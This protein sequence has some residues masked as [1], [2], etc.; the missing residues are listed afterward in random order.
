MIK[1]RKIL[2]KSFLKKIEPRE[3]ARPQARA[4]FWLLIIFIVVIGRVLLLQPSSTGAVIADPYLIMYDPLE[5]EATIIANNGM[6][7]GLEFV[8]GHLGKGAF[9]KY[10]DSLVYDA[11]NGFS[12]DRGAIEMWIKPNWEPGSRSE[13]DHV[14]FS[15]YDKDFP[16]KRKIELYYDTAHTTIILRAVMDNK[17][18]KALFSGSANPWFKGQWHH[19]AATWGPKY[20]VRVYLD[21]VERGYYRTEGSLVYDVNIDINPSELII[22]RAN[23]AG[24]EEYYPADAVIDEI[25]VYNEEKT[26]FIII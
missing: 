18:Y 23:Q 20:G 17:E 19:I 24:Y 1:K 14:F 7:S 12:K 21:G 6:M 26:N 10:G 8:R 5:S 3:H 15:A 22:G 16:K 13:D 2:K 25:K 11:P 4:N 9:Y